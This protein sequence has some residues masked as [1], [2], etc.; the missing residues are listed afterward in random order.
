MDS[1][2]NWKKSFLAEEHVLSH[3]Q[4]FFSFLPKPLFRGPQNFYCWNPHFLAVDA[5][6][7]SAE[8]FKQNEYSLF[9]FLLIVCVYISVC[10]CVW[11]VSLGRKVNQTSLFPV[12]VS[13]QSVSSENCLGFVYFLR[14]KKVR[15][16]SDS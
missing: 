2:G 14:K 1:G 12:I 11:I 3:N 10:A 13:K 6:L 16:F 4:I 7:F 15:R 5:W 9:F 8:N